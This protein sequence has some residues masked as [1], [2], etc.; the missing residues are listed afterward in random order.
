MSIETIKSKLIGR[1]AAPLPDFY[2][3]R[4]VFWQDPEREFEETLEQLTIPNVKIVKLTGSNNFAVKMLLAETDLTSNFLVYNPVSYQDIRDNWLLDIECYSEEFRADFLSMRMEELGMPE[5]PELRKLVKQYGKF[6]DNKERVA[7]L[8]AF[9]SE[10]RLAGQLHMDILAVLTGAENNTPFAII[11]ALL[12]KGL[13]LTEN[14]A[15]ESIKKFGDESVLW[16]MIFRYTG[17]QYDG[18]PGL[19]NLAAHLF[20]TALSAT[21]PESTLR[22]YE[23]FIDHAYQ[24]PCYGF[25]DEWLHCDSKSQEEIYLEIA[26]TVESMLHLPDFFAKI[27][28]QD[29]L[30]CTCFPSIDESILR[31]FLTEIAEGVIK[32]EAIFETVEKRRTTRR[33]EAYADYYEGILQAARMQEFY[34]A[35]AQGFTIAEYGTLWK[36]YADDYYRM[37]TYYRLFHCAFGKSLRKMDSDLSDLYKNAAEY[38]ENL[39]KNW[40]L[41][42][43]GSKWTDLTTEELSDKGYLSGLPQQQDF[44]DH[45]VSPA[46]GSG[47]RVYVIVS[48]ALRYEVAQELTE[49]LVQR[50][51]GT[52]KIS[53][54]QGIFPSVTKFGMA[55]LLPHWKLTLSEDLRALCDSM[56]TEGISN[57]EKVLQQRN[58]NS[59]AL[60]YKALLS[61]K[62]TERREQVAG[63]DV[64]YIYHDAIDAIGDK[65]ATEDQVFEACEEAISQLVNL[66]R[67]IINDLSGSHIYITADHGFLYSYRPLEERDKVERDL[68]SGAILEL[69]HRY[70][71]AEKGSFA[72]H[73][74][75]VPLMAFHSEYMGF[76][77]QEDIRIKKQGG[78]VNYVHGGIS[79][80]ELMVPVV[81]FQNFRTGAK[82][83]VDTKK[84]ELKLLSQSRKISN[85]IF[86]L[87]FYQTEA[88]V[89]KT[90][91]ETYQVF[92]CDTLG[93]AV[94][95]VQTVIADKT[96]AQDADRTFR[97]RFTLKNLT[98]DKKAN[99]YLTICRKE[100]GEQVQQIS[101]TIDIA[102]ASEFDF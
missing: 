51:K 23:K 94:S 70:V 36:N 3:R 76:T 22:G 46:K 24:G 68:V 21:L 26:E 49:Q 52:A 69:D 32:V 44:Y 5:S 42:T 88:A 75:R 28:T 27:E 58:L 59:R 62:K 72:S 96:G 65:R 86:A 6:F 93:S 54:R 74:I 67:L 56:S 82:G 97:L 20:M 16:R 64:V 95:D 19:Q 30:G 73:M 15:M 12:Q 9:G 8:K 33:Y 89:G 18:E 100:T 63:A 91:P 98:Y 78:G 81:E 25:I 92:L 48:D 90:L 60:T 17:W 41:A 34:Q 43:L 29:L 53:A 7:K 83:F 57:R 13:T 1:F 77:P 10:Y 2:Q 40:Y 37:D 31:R 14:P 85:N 71:I 50:T 99:Y 102:F 79:L 66:V 47:S 101:F 38:I 55:A 35:H 39:Y 4:I 87:D 11:R 84:A 80:Q 45:Y 61:M